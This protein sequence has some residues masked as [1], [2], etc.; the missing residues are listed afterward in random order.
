MCL[1]NTLDSIKYQT[2]HSSLSQKYYFRATC[3]D[4]F[5]SSSDP[6]RNRSEFIN[7]YSAFRDPERLQ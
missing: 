3:F 6:S 5:E 7:V 2:K 1:S 4:S